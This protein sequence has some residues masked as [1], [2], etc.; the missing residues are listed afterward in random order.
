MGVQ[1]LWIKACSPSIDCKSE[2][3]VVEVRIKRPRV[4]VSIDPNTCPIKVR[5]K[6]HS[7]HTI[8]R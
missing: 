3:V 7:N 8:R 5:I 1:W 2:S 4:I 6:I